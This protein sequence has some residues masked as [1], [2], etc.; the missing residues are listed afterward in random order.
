MN[1]AILDLIEFS[2]AGLCVGALYALTGIGFVVVYKATRIINFA[3]GEFMMIGAYF[4]FGLAAQAAL[5][6]WAAIALALIAAGTVGGFL[7]RFIFRRLIG[8]SAISVFMVTIGLA[9]IMVGLVEIAWTADP[10]SLPTFLPDQPFFVPL[11]SSEAFLASKNGW[12]F[13]IVAATMAVFIT[14]FR[15]WRGG[16]ALRA[17]AADQ[18]AAYSVGINVP[19]VFSFAWILGAVTAAAAGILVGSI[20]GISS[21][22]GAIG[23]SVIVVVIV[24]G[25][26]SLAGAL[27]GGLLIGWLEAMASLYLGGEYKQVATFVIL[28]LVLIVKPYGLFG[29]RDIERL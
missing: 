27:V 16:I 11:G 9:S 4:F 19:G 1:P 26:D 10:R 29:T 5:P 17:T 13:I 20:S 7:E 18:Q 8:E 3:I 25:L 15:F 23:L 6:N 2:L 24:G 14:V 12:S 22:M 21:A 28:L